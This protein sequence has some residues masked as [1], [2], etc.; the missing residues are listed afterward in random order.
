MNRS[1]RSI[2]DANWS[3]CWPTGLELTNS[4]VQACT[5]SSAA[6]PPLVNARNRFS[7]DADWWYACTSRSAVGT[8][9]ACVGAMSFTM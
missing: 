6:K 4:C 3:Y 1:A 7:V 8:R 2:S 9:A 5:R